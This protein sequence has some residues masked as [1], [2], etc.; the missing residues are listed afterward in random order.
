MINNISNRSS[1]DKEYNNILKFS[2]INICDCK[3]VYN[4]CKIVKID[5]ITYYFRF[6]RI[7][8]YF[9]DVKDKTAKIEDCFFI[10]LY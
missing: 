9:L 4:I 7:I 2:K 10:K 3:N 8:W 1:R 5:Y 6:Y